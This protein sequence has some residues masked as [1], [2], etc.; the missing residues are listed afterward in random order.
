MDKGQGLGNRQYRRRSYVLPLSSI[1]FSLTSIICFYFYASL[2]WQFFRE[3]T[4]Q[5]HAN[6]VDNLKLTS[7]ALAVLA[8]ATAVINYREQPWWLNIPA[9]LL[10]LVAGTTIIVI[11]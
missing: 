8:F 2:H 9:L 10:S 1:G 3:H 6:L 5:A 4:L 7:V 11:M